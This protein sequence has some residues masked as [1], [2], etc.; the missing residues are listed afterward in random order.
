M[1]PLRSEAFR[2]TWHALFNRALLRWWIVGVSFIAVNMGFLYLFVDIA[3]LPV[4]VATLLAAEAGTLLRFIIN[5]RWVF[6]R[7]RPTWQ[8]LWQYHVANAMSL[9]IWWAGTNVFSHLGVH[10]LLASILAMACSVMVSMLTNFLWIWRHGGAHPPA[11]P[12]I[13]P[14]RPSPPR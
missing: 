9:F 3:K 2:R 6:G 8:R 4:F 5:D 1:N 12:D 7:S 10:Y 11:N 13:E 14:L